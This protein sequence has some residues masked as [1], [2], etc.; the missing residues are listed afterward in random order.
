MKACTVF[1]GGEPVSKQ[2]YDASA[3]KDSF[4]IAADSGYL[5]AESL[6]VE[7]QLIIGDFDSAEKPKQGNVAAY[8][9]EKDDTDLMLA[10]KEGVKQGCR[11]FYFFGATGGRLDHTIAAVQALAFLSEHSAEGKIIS[12]DTRITLLTP[13]EYELENLEGFSLSLFSYSE[14]VQQLSLTGTKYPCT[15]LTLT[16]SFPLG[17]SNEIISGSAKLSF[18]GGLLLVIRSK[19]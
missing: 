5:L 10:V 16:Q 15:D 9:P 13:G 4:L 3:P 7:P 12:D 11:S 8:P 17:I 19:L 6:G 1:C 14:K 2:V 18:S